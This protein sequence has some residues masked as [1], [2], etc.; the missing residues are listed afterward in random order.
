MVDVTFSET[1]FVVGY[2]ADHLGRGPKGEPK[3][4]RSYPR[5]AGIFRAAENNV[6]KKRLSFFGARN[7]D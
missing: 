6:E 1:F 5:C 2:I 7:L 4:E 3:G